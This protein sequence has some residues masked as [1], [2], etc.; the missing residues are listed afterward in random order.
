MSEGKA[1]LDK[2]GIWITVGV[3][4]GILGLGKHYRIRQEAKR[5]RGEIRTLQEQLE[6]ET[7]LA[8]KLAEDAQKQAEMARIGRA[9]CRGRV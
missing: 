6:A 1:I 5:L 8:A 4:V 2:R 3:V 9:S 7:A